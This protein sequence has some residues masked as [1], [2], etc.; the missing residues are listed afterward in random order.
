M[1]FLMLTT[2]TLKP[3]LPLSFHG[4]YL[5]AYSGRSLCLGIP[6]CSPPAGPNDIHLILNYASQVLALSCHQPAV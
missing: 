5:F 4:P 2:E 6:W 1:W 3:K